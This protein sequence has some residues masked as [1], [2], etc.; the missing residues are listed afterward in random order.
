M[1]SVRVSEMALLIYFF[2]LIALP[3]W[4]GYAFTFIAE[5]YR[6]RKWAKYLLCVGVALLHFFPLYYFFGVVLN[7]GDLN[8][9][10]LFSIHFIYVLHGMLAVTYIIVR[11]AR[12]FEFPENHTK[13]KIFFNL[14][15]SHIVV[16]YVLP[17]L[18]ALLS[19]PAANMSTT[20]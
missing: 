12:F 15:L 4:E 11:S 13:S 7:Y 16:V 1:L 17:I 19:S 6:W 3:T 9:I 2:V 20:R 5:Q 10:T 8:G 14:V 18:L